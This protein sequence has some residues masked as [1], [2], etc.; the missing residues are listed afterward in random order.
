MKLVGSSCSGRSYNEAGRKQL[1]R[2]E[3]QQ[4]WSELAIQAGVTT[5]FVVRRYDEARRNDLL[6]LM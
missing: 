3:L 4:S 1:F 5:N 2:Q 6:Y